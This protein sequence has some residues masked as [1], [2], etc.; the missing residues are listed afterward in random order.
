MIDDDPESFPRKDTRNKK[1]WNNNPKIRWNF[2][3]TVIRNEHIA[4]RNQQR[5]KAEEMLKSAKE[6]RREQEEHK[7]IQDLY[8]AKIALR[9][10]TNLKR[11]I[12]SKEGNCQP[13]KKISNN[14]DLTLQKTEAQ[15]K[16][17]IAYLSTTL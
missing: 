16:K 11:E 12:A 15:I 9:D 5:A 8:Q 3:E 4:F 13:V 6:K 7:A 17:Y 2:K 10:V 1:R 14:N